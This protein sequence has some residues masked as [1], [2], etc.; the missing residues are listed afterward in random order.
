MFLNKGGNVFGIGANEHNS[1]VI[2]SEKSKYLEKITKVYPLEES[3]INND[4]KIKDIAAGWSHVMLLTSNGHV[5]TFGRNN[6]GQL[7]RKTHESPQ[8]KVDRH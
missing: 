6:F 7:G 3:Y 5:Q 4:D 8:L 2:S 1:L